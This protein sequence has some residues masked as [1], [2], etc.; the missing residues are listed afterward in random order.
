M[1]FCMVGDF[2][3]AD[4]VIPFCLDAMY[5]GGWA[6]ASLLVN[7][8][9]VSIE[10]QMSDGD[11]M[12][13]GSECFPGLPWPLSTDSKGAKDADVGDDCIRGVDVGGICTRGV[14]TEGTYTRDACIRDTCLRG[15]DVGVV[16]VGG[17]CASNTYARDTCARNASSTVGACIKG[18]GPEGICGSAYKPSESSVEGSRLLVKSGLMMPVSSCLRS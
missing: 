7:V 5:W 9:D 15:A 11:T 1:S 14:Y 3:S 13:T 6:S 12:L 16:C 8:S 17:A 18:V 10:K 4:L 2:V